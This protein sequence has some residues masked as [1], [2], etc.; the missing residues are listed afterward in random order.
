M[1]FTNNKA[2]IHTLS[3]LVSN[4]PGVLQRVAQVF[5]RR[6]FNINSLVVSPDIN[7]R[8]SRMTLTVQGSIEEFL[9]ILKVLNKLVD[10]IHASDHTNQ[11]VIAKE[12][13]L[14]KVEATGKNRVEILQLVDHFKAETV[15]FTEESLVIQVA[16]Y[17]DK[18][19]AFVEML[20]KIGIIEIV[21]TGKLLMARGKEQT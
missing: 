3:I 6:G 8:F 17:T 19:D 2:D 4:N 15:D 14:I 18:L 7:G 10:V 20:K 13:A 12:L 16:G 1:T 5:S 9:Q 11:D 21:R